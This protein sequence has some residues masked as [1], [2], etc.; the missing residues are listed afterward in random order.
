MHRFRLALMVAAASMWSVAALPQEAAPA[1]PAPN[2]NQPAESVPTIPVAPAQPA[3]IAPA[4]SAG[5][6]TH[7]D[8]IVVTATKRA[9]PVRRIAGTLT[10]LSGED[11]ERQGVQGIDQIVSL[12]PGVNLADD[13]QGQAKRVTIRGISADTNVNFTAGTLF[14]DIPFS[15]PYIPKV[16]MDPNPFDMATVEI[17]KGPQGTLFGGSGLNGMIRYVPE[18]PAFDGTHLKYYAQFNDFPG[19]GGRGWSSGA[20][21][22]APFAGDSAALRLM[23]FHRDAPGY[24]DNTRTGA[25]DVNSLSQYG[26]RGMLTWLPAAGWKVTLMGVGQHTLQDDVAFTD[27]FNGQLSRNNTPRPSPTET[28]YTLGNLGLEHSL[29]W[30]DFV[31]QTSGFT[32]KWQAFLDSSRIAADGSLPVLGVAGFDQ[33]HAFAQELRLVSPADQDSPWKWLGGAFYYRTHLFDCSEAFADAAGALGLPGVI[34]LGS[35]LPQPLVGVTAGVA[36][37]PC[38]QNMA[39]AR[40]TLDIAHLAGDI[41]LEERALFGELG[42]RF[43]E[44][45]E[46]TLGA[47]LYR[48]QSSGTVSNEGALYSAQTQGLPSTR[49]AGVKEQ[50]VSPKASLVYMP[51]HDVRAYFTASRGFRFGGIQIGSSTITTT[52]PPVFKSDSLW[53]Y[54]LGLRTDW[55][56]RTLQLDSSLYLIDWKNPQVFQQSRDGLVTFIDNVGGAQG[57]GVDF[58]ARWLV[59]YLNGLTLTESASLNRTVTT[60]PFDSSTGKHVPSGSAWPLAPRWQTSTTLAYALPLESWRSAIALRHTFSSSACNVIECGAQVLGYRTFN[61][62]LSAAPLAIAWMPEI[63]LSLDNLTDERGI[64]TVA[65]STTLGNAVNYIPPRALTLRLGG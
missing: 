18:A 22:N 52:I 55:L 36:A 46:L 30:A 25:K 43:G 19:N 4:Q 16:Q 14:G 7:L 3:E 58:S 8:D 59:P 35:L 21:L 47:R 10:V 11:L 1:D 12:V 54:E 27:N 15:D 57:R 49:N 44:Q 56:D 50:G 51:T 39:Y 37:T 60:V 38:A 65:Q 48:T 26:Y 61:L 24:V 17:L 45:W 13:G 42:R 53:N 2:A 6:A 29:G 41:Q 34:D 32:K 33:S 20:V 63:S 9:T 28:T 40:G 64:S 23:G 31:S 62:S 5:E